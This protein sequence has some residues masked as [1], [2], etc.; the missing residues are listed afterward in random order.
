MALLSRG[1]IE[2]MSGLTD[3][4]SSLWLVNDQPD[5]VTQQLMVQLAIT[6]A[7]SYR[8]NLPTVYALAPTFLFWVEWQVILAWVLATTLAQAITTLNARLFLKET[9]ETT[10]PH[11]ERKIWG[12]RLVGCSAL[13]SAAFASFVILF[14]V[15]G[16][17]LNN[18]YLLAVIAISLAPVTLL[19]AAYL[20][21]FLGAAGVNSI[22]MLTSLLSHPN[23][24]YSAMAVV[25]CMFFVAMTGHAIR[26]N[27]AART[28]IEMSIEKNALIEALSEAKKRSDEA[29]AAAEDASHAKSQF[30]ANMSH[31]LRTPLNAIIGFS[32]VI[33]R[34]VFGPLENEKYIQYTSDIHSSGHHLLALIN[35]ILDL[36]KIEAGQYSIFEERVELAQIADECHKLLDLRASV[37]NISLQRRF[38]GSLP[39]LRADKRAIRQIWLNLLT[40]AVKFAPQGS[41]VHIVADFQADGSFRIGVNDEG[42]G[43]AADEL[44]RVQET[45]GQGKEGIARP[46]SGTGL[47]LSIVKGLSEAHGGLF[48]L[49]SEVGVGTQAYV[50]FPRDRVLASSTES[51]SRLSK[52]YP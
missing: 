6:H 4:W 44:A 19:N 11:R 50:V 1:A 7:T 43:I 28:M 17:L 48:M 10:L 37:N 45:F 18:F 14:W 15:D 13:Y 25:Y 21:N 27:R 20:P 41:S 38:A 24:V 36:S 2:T 8:Q 47:G 33:N 42:P 31:E 35:D 32:E 3:W 39:D 12:A 52:A 29:R 40:N 30:L 46:G 49:E 9:K 23:P 5:Q 51:I 22:F 34:Q 26:I 16:V